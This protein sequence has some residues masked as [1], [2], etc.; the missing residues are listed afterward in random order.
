YSNKIKGASWLNESQKGRLLAVY[1]TVKIKD[2]MKQ[3]IYFLDF[4]QPGIAGKPPVEYKNMIVE[5]MANWEEKNSDMVQLLWS[6]YLFFDTLDCD[7]FSTICKISTAMNYSDDS[8]N[9]EPAINEL[10]RE[11]LSEAKDK[12][13]LLETL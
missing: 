1:E 7:D 6:L 4:D 12:L 3:A 10:Y 9:H 2:I 8:G 13:R 11:T 5:L